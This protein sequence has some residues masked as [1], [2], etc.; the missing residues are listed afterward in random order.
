MSL[1]SVHAV[2]KDLGIDL[3]HMDASQSE[4]VLV[5]SMRRDL[6]LAVD[7]LHKLV[8]K[9]RTSGK[10]EVGVED[11]NSTLGKQLTRIFAGTALREL[12]KR[13]FCHGQ[14]LAFLNCCS[15]VTGPEKPKMDELIALQ[16]KLQDG[17]LASADC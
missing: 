16:I 13:H 11:P 4:V 8:H 9:S 7:Y 17:R 10:Q 5:E 6:P 14:E 12:A 3:E 2:A 1:P 15:P